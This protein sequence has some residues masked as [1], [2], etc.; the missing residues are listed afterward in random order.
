MSSSS[1]VSNQKPNESGCFKVLPLPNL[2][3]KW[4]IISFR[5][6]LSFGESTYWYTL[7]THFLPWK[8]R[9]AAVTECCKSRGG[10]GMYRLYQALGKGYWFTKNFRYLKMAV[11]ILIRLVL[12]WVFPYISLQLMQVSTSILGTWNV[13]WLMV[14]MFNAFNLER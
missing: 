10:L 12:G 3:Q 14:L 4:W 9:K 2:Q 13:W 5:G 6:A 1:L 11:L 7:Y 8:M